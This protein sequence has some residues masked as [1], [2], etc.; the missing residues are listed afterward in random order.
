[1]IPAKRFISVF[2]LI[3]LLAATFLAGPV[4]VLLL[5]RLIGVLGGAA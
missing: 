1:M 3:L 2:E 5:F 4:A